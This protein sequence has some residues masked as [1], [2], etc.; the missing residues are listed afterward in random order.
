MSEF[1]M[2]HEAP[3]WRTPDSSV[4]PVVDSQIELSTGPVQV[5]STPQ[6]A[7]DAVRQFDETDPAIQLL[8]KNAQI[9]MDNHEF[10]LAE[11][12]LRTLLVRWSDCDVAIEKMGLCLREL[13]RHEDSIKCFRALMKIRRDAV[14]MS[15]VAECLY[16]M[17]RDQQALEAY[18]ESLRLVIKDQ[19]RLFETYK[20]IGNIHTRAGDLDAAEEFYNKAYAICAESDALLVNYG[21]LEIQR[22]HFSEAVERFRRAVEINKENDRAWTGL[23]ILHRQMGDAELAF[24]N[25]ER[26]LDI[27]ANNRTALRLQVDWAAQ[28]SVLSTSR[29]RLENYLAENGEDAEMSF[30][31]AKVLTHQG[32]FAR[33]AHRDGTSA[34]D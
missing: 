32:R 12:L 25:I 27:N 31:L 14:S 1:E 23:A 21:T 34:R 6:S 5:P 17:Q 28:D 2:I 24:G 30:T 10:R 7:R 9:L 16:L 15:Q 22:G 20:N 18:R 8:L 33:S 26:A 4:L 3:T 11:H 13:G 19:P 29:A